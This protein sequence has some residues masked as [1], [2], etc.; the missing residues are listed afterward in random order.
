MACVQTHHHAAGF[1]PLRF[2]CS[3]SPEMPDE[4][5]YEDLVEEMSSCSGSVNEVLDQIDL[6][7][8]RSGSVNEVL[9]LIDTSQKEDLIELESDDIKFDGNQSVTD[10]LT[11]IIPQKC[12]TPKPITQRDN[13]RVDNGPPKP[14]VRSLQGN[15]YRFGLIGQHRRMNNDIHKDVK[16]HFNDKSVKDVKKVQKTSKRP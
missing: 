3:E 12:V 8:I 1:L 14:S 10:R 13:I 4:I 6:E 5:N 7:S 15:Q 9:D 11:Q 2:T 16:T